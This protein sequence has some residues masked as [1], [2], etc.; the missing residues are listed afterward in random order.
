MVHQGLNS[1]AQKKKPDYASSQTFWVVPDLG[2]LQP[3]A[4]FVPLWPVC[5]VSVSIGPV[6]TLRGAA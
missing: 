1:H 5:S 6:S 4:R 3:I 2:R